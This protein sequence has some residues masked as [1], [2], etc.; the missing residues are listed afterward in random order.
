[1]KTKLLF[2]AICVVSVFG[3]THSQ[4]QTLNAQL[5][6]ISPGLNVSGSFNG[7]N[8]WDLYV[9]AL[10]FDTFQ[11]FCTEP[12][13]GTSYGETYTFQVTNSAVLSHSNE[14]SRLLTAYYASPQDNLNAAAVQWAIWEVIVESGPSYSLTTGAGQVYVSATDTYGVAALANNYLANMGSYAPATTRYLV[15]NDG[16]DVIQVVP[17]SSALLL[18]AISSS[19]LLF[20]RRRK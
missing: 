10:N 11:A 7:V 15:A 20:R 13:V 17:E 19:T 3:S 9:G 1:M 12:L 16:Q 2:C 8:N 4:A 6:D 5:I 14:V 18:A